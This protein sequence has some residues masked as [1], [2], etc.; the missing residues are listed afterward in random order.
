MTSEYP[1]PALVE[2]RHL[3]LP[4][5]RMHVAEAGRGSPV[6]LL[7]GV[8][9]HWWEWRAVIPALAK[10]YRVI[11]PDLRGA[12]W[13]QAP[14]TG[15]DRETLVGDL[16]N[17]LDALGLDRVRIVAHDWSA[18]AA[19]LLCL[20]H[21]DRV[22]SYVSLA[23]PHPYMRFDV[24][25][26]GRFRN[27]WYQLP[28]LTPLV[29]VRGLAAGRQWLARQML[30]YHDRPGAIEGSDLDLF[31]A[32]LRD[33]AYA[34]AVARLYRGFI[35]P[36]GI[37]MMRGAYRETRLT[38]PTLVLTGEHDP[39]VRADLLG[40][41]TGNADDLEVREIAGASHFLV[42]DQPEIV[43]KHLLEFFARH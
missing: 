3:D 12:G 37:A 20:E 19:F 28:L 24:R 13:T 11:V 7:H 43:V 32:P 21:S 26:L 17:L 34:K 15:Y 25:L 5:L 33:R 10:D 42:D 22:H 39:V 29:G 23:I 8:P 18:I 40:G 27:A 41:P 36:T 30:S 6:V 9:Q 14:A 16:L 2:H 31:L 38:T 1:E 35:L 4:G